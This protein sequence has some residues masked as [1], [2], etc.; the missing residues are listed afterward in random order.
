[1]AVYREFEYILW[2]LA[3]V[4]PGP[5]A[6]WRAPG[7]SLGLGPGALAAWAPE[8]RARAWDLVGPKAQAGPGLA[9]STTL[10]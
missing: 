2:A 1:M 3:T 8:P 4:G 9:K 7:P 6:T 10:Q 5:W